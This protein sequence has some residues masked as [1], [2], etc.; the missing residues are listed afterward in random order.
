VPTDLEHDLRAYTAD[1]RDALG[2]ACL[3]L[4]LYGSAAGGDWVAGRSDVNTA[5]VVLRVDRAVL[6]ALVPVVGRWRAK[7]FALPLVVDPS[8]LER[9]RDSFPIELYDI[10][11]QHRV[12]AGADSFATLAVDPSALRRECEQEARGK[13]LRLRALY[14]EHAGRPPELE[15]LLTE[16][17][18]SF[19]AVLRHVLHLRHTA[20]GPGYAA[21]L[22]AGEAALGP[23]P[24]MR[25]VLALRAGGAPADGERLRELFASYLGDVERIVAAVDAL[26]A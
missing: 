14:L 10:Q 15:R 6:D 26:G 18:K 12:L 24:A 25:E 9:A 7:G 22:D 23:L 3:S 5:I 17:L 21:V 8:Y 19:L 4:V 20:V 1:V 16:S 2:D 11:R 13:L